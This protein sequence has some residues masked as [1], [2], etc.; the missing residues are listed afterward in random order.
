MTKYYLKDLISSNLNSKKDIIKNS[1]PLEIG[2]DYM[3]KIY[4]QDGF[5]FSKTNYNIEKPI[6]LEAKQEERKFV[7]TISLKGN[8]TYINSGDKK[9]IP[10]KEGFTTISMFENT[11][12][13][14]EFKDKQINQIR[15]ILSESF[16]R[17]NFQK[18]LVEKYFF[19]KQNLQ[20]I[21]F[22]LTSI[23]S[24]F[25][26]NDI[27][28]CSLV[29]ELANI[30]KQGKI[31]ELLSLEISK[32][33]KNEDDISLDDYDRSA[34][35]KAKE[36]LLNNLQNPPSIVTLS[37]MVHLSEVKLKRGFKQIYKTSPYQLLVSHKMNLA[38]NMLESGE[39]NINEIA[40]QVGYKFANN[41]TNAFYKEFKIRPK[42]ILKK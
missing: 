21:D 10:F 7:I 41:F 32:L 17:R 22:R 19:N 33:Q 14:R 2:T 15:L 25:L 31:F 39:Y 13:F 3:E 35:L 37:K 40:L 16:L 28:N 34:I 8:T 1:F 11:Q 4:I 42:D 23:Q 12:G 27:L 5:L 24:Q 26:L 30:Y 20:L 18:S 29:G 6:F 9:I 38:K 36:I